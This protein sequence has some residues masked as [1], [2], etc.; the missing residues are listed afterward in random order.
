[1]MHFKKRARNDRCV[2]SEIY[3]PE[4]AFTHFVISVPVLKAHSLAM[5]TGALKNM[6][7]FAPPKYY[8]EQSGG[9]KKSAFHADMQEALLDLIHYRSPDLAIMDASVGLSDYH[10]GGRHCDPPVGKILA[11]FDP[12]A[13]DRKA[14]DLLGLDWKNIRHLVSE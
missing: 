6:M 4:I 9:W 1:M 8:G 2:F 7:G 14:A 3:L 5:L 12:M 10:L 11:G 13:V